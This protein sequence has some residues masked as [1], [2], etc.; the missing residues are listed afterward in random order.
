[1]AVMEGESAIA[2]VHGPT[3]EALK[4]VGATPSDELQASIA[5]MRDD[6][7]QQLDARY[8]AARGFADA[9]VYPENTRPLLAHALRAV[10]RNPGPHL[11]AFVL[12][13]QPTEMA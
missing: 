8:A 11:G 9:I 7:E 4:K 2:A 13:P 6:Y 3:L 1:M 12:P 5:S 10:R